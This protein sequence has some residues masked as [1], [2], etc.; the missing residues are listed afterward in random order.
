MK[1]FRATLLLA[2][3]LAAAASAPLAGQQPEAWVLPRGL[4]EL[5]AGG[6]YTHYDRQ[7][8]WGGAGLG[9]SLL[10]AYQ[11]AADR[12]LAVPAGEARS[13]VATLLASLPGGE[14]ELAG[15]LTTGRAALGLAAD[16]RQVPVALRYGL[17]ARLTLFASV[18]V[19]RRETAVTGLYL[20]GANLGINPA[21][22]SNRAALERIDPAF[23]GAGGG[24]LLPVAGSP[25]ALAIQARLREASPGDTLRLPAFPL[26]MADLLASEAL[27][28]G[29]TGEERSALDLAS[30]RRPYG[31]GDLRV[32]ARLL[33]L[34]GP[35]GWPYP[36]D[37]A[38]GVRTS[39]GVHGRIPTG[40]SGTT[41]LI[42]MPAGGGHAGAGVELLNDVFL[43][44]RWSLHAG[45][46][47]EHALPADVPT[48][49]FAP[50]RPF[51]A[52]SAVRTVRRAPGL[53]LEALL[54]PRWRLTEEISLEGRYALVAR[55]RTTYT[56]SDG[57]EAPAPPVEWFTG[58][59]AHAAGAA[60]RYS[61]LSAYARDG[62]A[63][64][65][66]V[67]LGLTTT[68]A[69]AGG[70]PRATAIR[71]TGRVFVDRQRLRAVLPADPPAP[72]A[73]PA[74]PPPP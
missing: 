48:L 10:P 17:T 31:L 68:L 57:G 20:A 61:T 3:G 53:H 2:A 51:P 33:L 7:L 43:S 25:A 19:E 37:G 6:S 9:A 47:L 59:S 32:G 5:S 41:F 12:A 42:E 67:S 36:R 23:A 27:A 13:G 18:A 66:E 26:R 29:L 4:L 28:A 72:P 52:D 62:S 55:A 45:A 34:P 69:G 54:S 24:F 49:A 21:P 63:W 16:V 58:G 46:S 60:V 38:R 14:P 35:P 40:R 74:D 11:A 44:R 64:P 56:D 8:G 1:P 73:A 39:L 70:A 71:V 65:Y 50:D 30:D 15:T 22:D